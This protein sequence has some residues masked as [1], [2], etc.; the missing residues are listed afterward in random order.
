MNVESP[1]PALE[2]AA[3]YDKRRGERRQLAVALAGREQA[4][5]LARAAVALPAL[6]TSCLWL[7]VNQVP[8]WW[9]LLFLAAFI[10]LLFLHDAAFRAALRARRA[11]AY[12]EAG[13]RRLADD[14]K[15]QGQQ[16][17]RFADESHPYAADLDLFGPG[18]LFELLC[19]A[20]T[21]TGEETLAEWLKSGA[22]PDV[23]RARQA[24]VA[25]LRPMLDLREE[26]ALLGSDLP[27]GVDFD[28]VAAWGEEPP[29]LTHRWPRWL[30]L[31][32]G[33]VT[34]ACATGF[35][36]G[37]AGI[38]DTSTLLGRFFQ[39]YGPIPLAVMLAL[40]GVFLSFFLARVGKVLGSVERSGRDLAMLAHILARMEEAPFRSPLLAELLARL[41]AD[42]GVPPSQRVAALANLIDL[43]N[44]RRNQL[45]APFA[46]LMMW[47]TQ[48]AHDIEQWRGRHGRQIRRWLATV[49]QM[50]ALCALAAY[51]YESP[52]DPFP[53]V[54]VNGALLEAEGLAHPLLPRGGC[55]PNDVTLGGE[56]RVL[57]VSGSNMS[58]KS[59]FLRT[60]G[61]NVVLALAGAPVRARRMR[62]S[63]LVIGATLRIQDSL[64]AGRSRFYA[65]VLRVKQVVSLSRG[66]V[67]LMFL[68]DEVFAGTNSHDRRHGARAVIHGLVEAGA[69]GLVTTHDLALA[70]IADE[71]GPKALNVHFADRF[72]EGT[73]EFDYTLR[74]GVVRH[75]NAV[76]LMRAVGLNV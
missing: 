67:P 49:G 36:L 1:Q 55:V 20:R 15:G 13:L 12:Y 19:T 63:P 17:L 60:I 54:V 29:L 4:L 11:A 38:L 22:A 62:L 58:G 68:L 2:P 76:A 61:T 30:A 39:D 65:E 35:V 10:A 45:F 9:L 69:I 5:S 18:S 7:R 70:E 64:Q 59:T 46:F 33:L 21:R 24:A 50:E 16:G 52:G 48:I 66:P 57:V 27:N 14:W 41:K 74:P 56:L 28:G 6:F 51:A 32:M 26:L 72:D 8:P 3:E 42:G 73:L 23:V 40:Q 71:L 43:L 53:E 47:G 75:S 25:E 37:L 34:V 31:G 44:S